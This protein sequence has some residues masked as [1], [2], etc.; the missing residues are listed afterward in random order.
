MAFYAGAAYLVVTGI[1]AGLM[2]L[3][4]VRAT[5]RDNERARL[6]DG[7]SYPTL[8]DVAV[9]RAADAEAPAWS[10]EPE[11][12]AAVRSPD[13][14]ERARRARERRRVASASAAHGSFRRAA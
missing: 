4:R 9:A 8:F 5:M 6:F 14:R 13:A 1:R 10:P 12:V 7:E 11:P 3:R 2:A